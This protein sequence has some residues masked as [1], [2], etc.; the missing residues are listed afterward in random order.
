MLVTFSSE[1]V[2][3]QNYL[4]TASLK[5]IA[6]T[7]ICEANDFPE[8]PLL[9]NLSVLDPSTSQATN[10]RWPVASLRLMLVDACT[11]RE[12]RL[13]LCDERLML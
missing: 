2:T 8:R 6:S 5:S 1:L 4:L 13:S 9:C 11:R 7:D 10:D 12:D 3:G